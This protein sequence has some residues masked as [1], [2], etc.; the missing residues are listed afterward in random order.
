MLFV[1][2]CGLGWAESVWVEGEDATSSSF[3][4]HSWYRA[5]NMDLLSPGTPGGAEGDWL[6]HFANNST[7]VEATWDVSVAD[8][9]EYVLWVRSASYRVSAWAQIDSED[10]I[11]LDLDATARETLNLIY[12]SIDVRFLSW[13]R[14]GTVSLAPGAHQLTVGL[15]PHSAWGGGQIYGGV[16]A[17]VL[18]N[19]GRAP[20]GAELPEP[21]P[22]AA[23]PAPED[24]FAFFPGDPPQDWGDSVAAWPASPITQRVVADGDQ[25]TLEDGSP[26]KLWGTNSRPPLRDD[27]IEQQAAMY[28]AMG[29][30]IVRLHS[31]FSLLGDPVDADAL[32]R[33]DRWFAALKAHGIYTQWSVFYPLTIGA[34]DGYSLYSELSGGSTSGVV[35]VSEDLQALEWAYLQALLAHENPYTKTTYAEDPALAVIEIRNED[36]VFWHAPLNT[37]MSGAMPLH[38]AALEADWRDWLI[39]EY[40]DNDGLAAAWGDGL[41]S[42]DD[43]TGDGL[44]GYGA[45]EL[46]A[47]GPSNTDEVARA[48]DWIRFLAQ[49]QRE[50]Y[51][52][53]FALMRDAGYDGLT[54]TTAWKSGGA[55][56][57][58]ANL[59]TDTAGDVIDR[60]TY[61]G[62]GAGEHQIAT[63]EIS[64]DA[65]L[66]D[67][68]ESFLATSGPLP[69]GQPFLHSEWTSKPPNEHTFEAAPLYALYGMGLHGWD[70]S[71]HF[72][73]STRAWIDG[74]WPGLSS[75]VSETPHYMGQYFALSRAV[76]E[77]H[78]TEA[79]PAARL[80][81]A[82]AALFGGTDARPD[83]DERLAALGP[84][85]VAFEEGG[86]DTV[87]D[88]DAFDDGA[89]LTSQ[90][91]SW[92]PGAH[93]R[94]SAEGTQ[95]VVGT[96][97]AGTHTLPDVSIDLSSEQGSLLLTALDGAP[98]SESAA[99]LVT[100]MGRA[101]QTGAAYSSDR[102]TLEA[103]GGPPLLLEPVQAQLTF[104]R[105]PL[106]VSAL[107]V[108]GVPQRE[109]TDT[110]PI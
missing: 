41:R 33:L 26:V 27:L 66:A 19:D 100:A 46:A 102:A 44:N 95:G 109:L 78:I 90:E 59:W 110:I 14:A 22:E 58:L 89:Y 52:A 29:I 77:Q 5:V 34:D 80:S 72:S 93:M 49:R 28:A 6:A 57:E 84:V 20:S 67:P 75:Y 31:V 62:G 40:G 15:E 17:F 48:G 87:I 25:L 76:R 91:L 10:P 103:V 54:I 106:S 32:D 53:R 21:E 82:D 23:E 7:P 8:G 36:S 83:L 43:L 88:A 79:P 98:L 37:L 1:V 74:G 38:E 107:D 11:E 108:Y 2:L 63:G 101:I 64:T 56:A 55:A 9:G 24:W 81:I 97:L 65:L 99:V 47:D 45:W 92:K 51:E 4:E 69:E 73:A 42:S 35:T 60:H 94:I 71:L 86:S 39:A 16:D 104:G 105:T 70:G 3:N 30:N 85:V 13:T 12:P 61:W 96:E 50:G 68:A 18:I